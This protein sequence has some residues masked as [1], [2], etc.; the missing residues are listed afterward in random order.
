MIQGATA[1]GDAGYFV[2]PTLVETSDPAY[3]LLCEEIFGPVVTA[4]VYEDAPWSQTLETIDRTSPYALTGSVFATDRAAVRRSHE[5]AAKRRRQLLHQRQA[6]RGRRRS[7]AVWRRA[8]IGHERQGGIEDQPAAVG[9]R[10]DDQGEVLA[11]AGVTVP[12]HVGGIRDRRTFPPSRSALRRVFTP[13]YESSSK[14]PGSSTYSFTFTRNWT[15]SRPS[16]TRWS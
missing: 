12:V 4:Y 13:A 15:A 2:E 3:R 5:R 10:A 14:F 16:T 1:R 8:R 7:A 11:A 9:E 6:N